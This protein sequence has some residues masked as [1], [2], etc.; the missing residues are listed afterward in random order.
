MF[1]DLGSE[2][3]LAG[4][5]AKYTPFKTSVYLSSK[6]QQLLNLFSFDDEGPSVKTA[7]KA[8]KQQRSSP[9]K[10]N[11]SRF[12]KKSQACKV[13]Q[14]SRSDSE[15]FGLH[16][17]NNHSYT[18]LTTQ[19]VSHRGRKL[20]LTDLSKRFVCTLCSGR[21]SR[22][23]HLKRHSDTIHTD[24]KPFK[25]NECGKK[26]SRIDGLSQHQRTHNS[27]T[28]LPPPPP[29]KEADL[30]KEK[31][32]GVLGAALFEAAQ[33][34]ADNASSSSLS[35]YQNSIRDSMS[36]TLSVMDVES[37]RK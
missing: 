14:I 8:L 11:P 1:S 13:A 27:E 12:K 29:M 32:A 30:S 24:D 35:E 3:E 17:D 33:A 34:A 9:Q 7:S 18:A 36:P 21:F 4:N 16:M 22:Q 6:K 28:P 19:L 5:L 2:T 37:M 10:T 25:C 31:D 23:A 26:F 20:N 15:F